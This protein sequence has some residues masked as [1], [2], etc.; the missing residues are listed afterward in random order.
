MSVR[1]LEVRTL[2]EGFTKL[3]VG[4][5][6]IDGES[7][8]VREIVDHGDS[9][10]ILPYDP[11]RRVAVL[12]RQFRAPVQLGGEEGFLLEAPAGRVE[13]EGAVDTARRELVEEIGVAAREM[14]HVATTFASPGILNER[15][16]LFLA[17]FGEADRI[18][19]GG[20]AEEESEAIEPV[21]LPLSVL[22]AMARQGEIADLKTLALVLALESRRPE[23]FAPG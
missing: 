13:E 18:G 7:D 3:V 14:E 4:R 23:L 22:G 20:G 2:H 9:V 21:V 17:V 6:R 10:A 16:H 8:V 1:L 19:E 5:F 11:L 12:T 15:I